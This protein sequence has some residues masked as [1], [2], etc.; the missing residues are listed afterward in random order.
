MDQ[1]FF[2]SLFK[3]SKNKDLVHKT[4]CIP[5]KTQMLMEKIMH[6]DEPFCHLKLMLNKNL[7]RDI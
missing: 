5:H 4:N 3:S 6:Y 2:V 1:T 7:S